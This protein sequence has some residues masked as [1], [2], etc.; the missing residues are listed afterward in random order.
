MRWPDLIAAMNSKAKQTM[1]QLEE[2][3]VFKLNLNRGE[4]REAIVSTAIRP[5]LPKRYGLGSG[6]VV[7]QDG[8]R[9]LALDILVYDALYSIV[10]ESVGGKLLCP[11]ESVFGT[12]E[13]KT[14]LNSDELA[15]AIGKGESL[16]N[17]DRE[18]TD[19]LQFTPTSGFKVGVGLEGDKRTRHHYFTGIVTVDAMAAENILKELN[20]AHKSG[21][22]YLPDMVVCLSKNWIIAKARSDVNGK[23][24]LGET[25]W[26]Y[27]TYALVESDDHTITVMN[28]ILQAKLMNINLPRSQA[29]HILTEALRTKNFYYIDDIAS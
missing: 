19:A 22:Q 26:G 20:W 4:L 9:S 17:I 6:E 15:D 11:A 29:E 23:M 25:E 13:V 1:S 24:T 28:L 14:T 27:D 18:A 21:V 12:I 8:D 7:G 2:A 3:E 5:W 10:F 16:A